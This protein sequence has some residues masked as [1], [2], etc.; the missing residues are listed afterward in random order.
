MAFVP[1]EGGRCYVRYRG[2]DLWHERLVVGTIDAANSLFLVCTPDFD[3][4]EEELKENTDIEGVRAGPVR[5]R[6]PP[7][8]VNAYSFAAL[9]AVNMRQLMT[10]GR[11]MA[12]RE[13]AIRFP[14]AA[15]P[16]G[17][18]SGVAIVVADGGAPPGGGAS[19]NAAYVQG[20]HPL[21]WR[22]LEPAGD[23]AVG[24]PIVLSGGALRM[25]NRAVDTLQGKTVSIA[26]SPLDEDIDSFKRRFGLGAPAGASGAVGGDDARTLAVQTRADGRRERTWENVCDAT[27]EVELPHFGIDGPRTVAW[28]LAFLRRQQMHPDDYHLRWRQRHRLQVVDWGVNQHQVAL[29]TLALAGCGDQLDLPNLCCMEHLAR[30][31]QMVEYY[32]RTQEREADEEKKKQKTMA[33]LPLKEV[34]LFLSAG[35]SHFESMVCPVLVEHVA[36]ALEREATVMK[37]S[38]KAREERA[39]AR[40]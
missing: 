28:C 35:K 23:L 22:L 5:G 3:I 19:G 20:A 8:I 16:S 15:P 13:V 9:S 37:Q 30:E 4:Y 40:G 29:R 14:V 2:F 39:L 36:K 7:G 31:A 18:S 33:G 12:A 17:A 10:E 21:R 38:R 26:S 11:A 25:E 24:A 34:E 6:R 32:Y 27:G 1:D